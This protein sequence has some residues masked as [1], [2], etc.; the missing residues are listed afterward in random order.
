MKMAPQTFNNDERR[1][2][3][4]PTGRLHRLVPSQ[5]G[6]VG[7]A[8]GGGSGLMELIRHPAP[9]PLEAV[10]RLVLDAVSSPSTRS[11]YATALDDFFA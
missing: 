8:V 11:M 1:C 7:W 3:E 9:V 6:P 4:H 10:K 5:Q 2:P